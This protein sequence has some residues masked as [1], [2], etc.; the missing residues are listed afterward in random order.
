M[1]NTT[2]NF[3]I[4]QK[5]VSIRPPLKLEIKDGHKSIARVWIYFIENDLHTSPWALIEDLWVHP[6]YRRSGIAKH[7]LQKVE[8][9]ARKE[10]CYKIVATVRDTNYASQK[11]FEHCDFKKHGNTLRKDCF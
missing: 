2:H 11:L 3:A 6:D 10:G 4:V 9:L 1:G 8:L 7:M 5:P